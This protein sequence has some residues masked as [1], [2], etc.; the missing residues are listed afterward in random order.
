MSALSREILRWSAAHHGTV[1]RDFLD[2]QGMSRHTLERLVREGLFERILDGTYRFTGSPADELARCV[3]VCTRPDRLVIAGPSGGRIWHYR[4]TPD[5]GLVH[6]IGAPASNP[7]RAPWLKVYRTAALSPLDIVTRD[8]GIRVT[9]PPR[10]A[11]DMVRFVSIEDARSIV[12][13]VLHRRLCT[14][15][16]MRRV[17]EGVDTPGRPWVKRFLSILDERTAGRVPESHWE[18]RV[19][20]ALR[21]RGIADVTPQ[22]WLDVPNWGW[23][24]LD[25]CVER[26]QWGVEVDVHPDHF[27]LDGSNQDKNRD[28]ACDAIGWRVSRVGEPSLVGDFEGS[29]DRLMAVYHRR[30]FEV[31]QWTR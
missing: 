25:A 17:A 9:S 28:L 10:T 16:T 21:D 29:I 4:R 14:V 22:R 3:A 13:D 24:R 26:L 18:S 2:A 7:S 1:T 15:A 19:V 23:V 27:S 6:A 20:A 31:A 8:D 30:A 12:D 5:D 11:L